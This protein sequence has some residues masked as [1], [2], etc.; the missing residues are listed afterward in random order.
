MTDLLGPLVEG[1]A[2]GK[3]RNRARADAAAKKAKDQRDFAL[4][5][6]AESRMV[7]G[8]AEDEWQRL[9]E[10]TLSPNWDP[11]R[12][13]S[14]LDRAIAWDNSYGKVTGRSAFKHFTKALHVAPG[15]RGPQAE[16]KQGPAS[17]GQ[18]ATGPLAGYRTQ[19]QKNVIEAAM[20]KD[21]TR[22]ALSAVPLEAAQFVQKNAVGQDGQYDP[23][24]SASA[25]LEYTA[26]KIAKGDL[27]PT[28]VYEV[29]DQ[30]WEQI[31]LMNKELVRTPEQAAAVATA[32]RVASKDISGWI[33]KRLGKQDLMTGDFTFSEDSKPLVNKMETSGQKMIQAGLDVPV[34]KMQLLQMY[35]DEN[36]GWLG[37]DG[38]PTDAWSAA[39][40]VAPPEFTARAQAVYNEMALNGVDPIIYMP[41]YDPDSGEGGLKNIHGFGIGKGMP[42]Y[43]P[44]WPPPEI[45]A[46]EEVDTQQVSTKADEATEAKVEKA[47]TKTLGKFSDYDREA[48]DQAKRMGSLT[49]SEFIEGIKRKVGGRSFFGE[50]QLAE[51]K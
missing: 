20:Q 50:D 41:V 37:A 26:Q 46:E 10:A 28:D 48:V 51:G 47:R 40:A 12:T 35:T 1:F 25:M 45:A 32:A 33:G 49:G 34:V 15:Q 21:R 36:G 31:A 11:A 19:G 8:A 44:F 17:P 14:L 38:G 23:A 24:L 2:I 5:L 30:V 4:K 42:D 18:A 29:T 22:R 9:E 39:M 3:E 43:I 16:G 6:G 13:G 7:T 27:D